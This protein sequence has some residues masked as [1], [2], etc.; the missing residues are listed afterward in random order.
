MPK[1]VGVS[2]SGPA[3]GAN[4]RVPDA[5]TTG[6]GAKN[7]QN[8]KT[9]PPA[10]EAPRNV[11]LS[12]REPAGGTN[13]RLEQAAVVPPP[14]VTQPA[15]GK[16]VPLVDRLPREAWGTLAPPGTTP[17]PAPWPTQPPRRRN[18]LE[19]SVWGG[20]DRDPELTVALD[21]SAY[22]YRPGQWRPRTDEPEEDSAGAHGALTRRPNR[23]VFHPPGSRRRP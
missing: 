5:I 15:P 18:P 13:D 22:V 20:V 4:D 19:D 2:V 3:G 14:A 7:L 1:N 23:S 16:Y 21:G 11:E 12:A 10:T 17:K 9:K 6:A 8:E